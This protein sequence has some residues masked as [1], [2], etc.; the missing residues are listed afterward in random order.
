MMIV[1]IVSKSFKIDS[2]CSTRCISILL[3]GLEA[4]LLLKSDLSSP[5]FVVYRLFMT[6][7]KTSNIDV[8]KCCQDHFGFD[9]PSVGWS[10]RVKKFEAKFHACNYLLCKI[11][12]L[13]I[14]AY[15][16]WHVRSN[17]NLFTVYD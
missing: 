9:L 14:I 12:P 5:D 11:T 1:C 3:Y 10:K 16:I 6:L 7:F 8:V 4:C 15:A 13:L 17:N 2:Q